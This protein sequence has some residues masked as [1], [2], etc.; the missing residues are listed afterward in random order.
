MLVKAAIETDEEAKHEP[1]FP[2]PVCHV[3]TLGQPWAS[4]IALGFKHMEFRTRF[5]HSKGPVVI[6]AGS[7]WYAPA[8]RAIILEHFRKYARHR[9]QA[10]EALFALTRPVGDAVVEDCKRWTDDTFAISLRQVRI[11]PTQAHG[12]MECS[13]CRGKQRRR[14][15]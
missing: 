15:N 1:E 7:N 2:C 3:I 12:L 11:L 8:L 5:C 6:H 4:L 9:G 13:L 14:K 10:V